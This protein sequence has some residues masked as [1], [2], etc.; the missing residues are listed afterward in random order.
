MIK[1][2]Y[3]IL[4][5]SKNSRSMRPLVL[6]ESLGLYMSHLRRGIEKMPF[7]PE[8]GGKWEEQIKKF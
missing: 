3:L 6:P 8:A 1:K 2:I 7:L 4:Y 5:Q